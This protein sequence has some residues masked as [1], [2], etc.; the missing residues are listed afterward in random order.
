MV[1]KLST[2]TVIIALVAAGISLTL[3]TA[4]IIATQT[5]TSNG[6]V[7]RINIGVYSESQCN[8]NCTTINWGTLDPG[9]STSKII[10]VKNTGTDPVTLTMTAESWAPKKAG[11][12]L[13]LTWDRQGTV[14][15]GGDSISANL[16]LSAA[17]DTSDIKN[18]SFDIVIKGEE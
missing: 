13:T 11:D 4:G 17:S 2:T 9:N 6:T 18:F 14:L 16:T 7:K 3:V 1:I 12:C 8:L 5:I 15:Q 10:Y